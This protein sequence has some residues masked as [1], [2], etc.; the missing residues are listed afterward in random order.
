MSPSMVA[1]PLRMVVTH[2][3]V[4]KAINT[5]VIPRGENQANRSTRVLH[6]GLFGRLITAAE[7]GVEIVLP[8]RIL[9]PTVRIFG[10]ADAK[11]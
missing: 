1:R 10:R 4:T 5:F 7:L 3:V 8:S 11:E 2:Y 9:T 6:D